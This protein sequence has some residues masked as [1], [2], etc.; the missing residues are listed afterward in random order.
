MDSVDRARTALE[1]G[2]ADQRREAAKTLFVAA[3]G[4]P[5]AV[6][7]AAD[8]LRGALEDEDPAVRGHAL[9]TLSWLAGRPEEE[10]VDPVEAPSE[11]LVAAL[12][13]PD[14][15]VRQTA[16][17]LLSVPESTLPE[18]LHPGA[19][20]GLVDALAADSDLIRLRGAETI[21]ASAV[22]VH[23]DP[24]TAVEALLSA[25]ADERADVRT[26]AGETLATLAIDHPDL[27]SGHHERLRD[28]L[29]ADAPDVRASAGFALAAMDHDDEAA[30]RTA[31]QGMCDL[32][33][34]EQRWAGSYWMR[35]LLQEWIRGRPDLVASA[36]ESHDGTP[37]DLERIARQIRRA[38]D[39]PR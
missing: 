11:R 15:G 34:V 7:Q 22:A 17:G 4:E 26:N 28:L 3:R 9:A 37:P 5:A 8:A 31:V 21:S 39:S 29:A 16:V 6:G 24:D 14:E 32:V 20:A 25:L 38:T 18:S 23:P 19:A 2:D 10:L 33:P 36:I 30:L 1:D 12:S 13:D 35:Q 27:L